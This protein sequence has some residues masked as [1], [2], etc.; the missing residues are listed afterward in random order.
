MLSEAPTIA[1][2]EQLNPKDIL[3]ARSRA[4]DQFL[5]ILAHE[6]RTP[7]SVILA[8]LEVLRRRGADGPTAER[9]R[10]ILERQAQHMLRL[11]DDLLDVYRIDRGKVQLCT[12]RFDLVPVVV[13]VVENV[14]PLMEQRRHYL[15]V[16]LPPEP[17][18][19]DADPMRLEQI[20]VNLLTN[21]AKY[22]EP[23]GRIWL[24][25][26]RG[27]SE[28]VLRVR[29]TGIGIAPDILSSIF[30]L[31]V[32]EKNGSQGGLG[33]GLHLVRGLVRL[34]GG[35][36]TAASAGPGQ[37]SEFVVHLPLRA[38]QEPSGTRGALMPYH[39]LAR[40]QDAPIVTSENR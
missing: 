18:Y 3:R 40:V 26:E 13:A 28:V 17:L 30:D 32:Q 39:A 27:H 11:I 9:T 12:T 16:V 19:L 29:D 33:I 5:A 10:D 23:G 35:T 36:V 38:S 37:G 6:L 25:V 7:L 22:T 21:A 34:H 31:F 8:S 4:K 15:D 14:N 20:L 2:H 24:L 1:P